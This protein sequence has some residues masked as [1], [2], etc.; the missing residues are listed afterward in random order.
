MAMDSHDVLEFLQVNLTSTGL[1]YKL[2]RHRLQLGLFTLSGFITANRPKA[3]LELRY[4]H[5]RVTLL[6]DPRDGPHRILLEFTYEFTKT[7]LG[8]KEA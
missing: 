8:M 1:A 2:G 6:R 4:R 3:T 5:L 7:Y